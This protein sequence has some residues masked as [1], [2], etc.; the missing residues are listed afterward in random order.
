MQEAENGSLIVAIGSA[1]VDILV[2]ETE[3]FRARSGAVKGGMTL[4]GAD[5]LEQ[6]LA[7]SAGKRAVV[8]GGSA[9]NTSIGVARL[10]GA[11]RFIGKRGLDPFGDLFEEKLLKNKVEAFLF[12]APSPTGRVLSIITPD[13]QRSMLTFLGAASETRVEEISEACF[14]GARIVHVEGYL[15]FN[16]ELIL[17]ALEAAKCAGASVSLDLASFTV[18]EQN[19]EFLAEIIERYVDILLANEDE[20]RVF[21]GLEDEEAALEA[22]SEKADLAVLK[23]GSR[24]S[25]IAHDGERLRIAP[26]DCIEAVDTTGAGDLWASG[27]LYGLVN[28]FPLDVCGALGSFCGA[29]VCR[30]FGAAIPADG[31][32]RIDARLALYRVEN[33]ASAGTEKLYWRN[34]GKKKDNPQGAFK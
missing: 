2:H 4:V 19:R 3:E 33:P 11:A 14:S 13:A 16:R 32:E 27:F 29:E 22:L 17:S 31:W 21:T 12:R 8:A 30:V 23:I 10:G 5:L 20:A 34:N 9:C 6:T 18:V 15:V 25:L 28:G 1:L 24:G 7:A 26:H